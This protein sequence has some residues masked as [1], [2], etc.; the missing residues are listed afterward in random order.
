MLKSFTAVALFSIPVKGKRF[1]FLNI[2]VEIKLSPRMGEKMENKAKN[3]WKFK[4]NIK[5]GSKSR[6]NAFRKNYY[7]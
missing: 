4:L 3:V 7:I 2:I 5:K 6:K 1:I